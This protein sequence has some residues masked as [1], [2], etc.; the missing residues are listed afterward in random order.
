MQNPWAF[1]WEHMVPYII[2]NIP[3]LAYDVRSN[4]L[5]ST[6]HLYIKD[7]PVQDWFKWC[8]DGPVQEWF[9]LPVGNPVQEGC[10]WC[11]AWWNRGVSDARQSCSKQETLKLVEPLHHLIRKKSS[12]HQPCLSSESSFCAGGN[13]H[14]VHQVVTTL[15]REGS[16]W[17]KQ[18]TGLQAVAMTTMKYKH[19]HKI[20]NQIHKKTQT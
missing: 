17:I 3:R 16:S 18:M 8:M 9:K 14:V 10:T 4:I 5:L 15:C 20:F 11:M 2:T 7:G 13:A 6:L 19:I 12:F 1:I